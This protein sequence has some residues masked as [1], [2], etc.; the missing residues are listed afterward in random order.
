MGRP[1]SSPAG[2]GGHPFCPPFP[3]PPLS[4]FV[5]R[6]G[7]G[8]VGGEGGG[9]G[10]GGRQAE[11]EAEAERGRGRETETEEQR[12]EPKTGKPPAF[13]YTGRE[14]ET[15]SRVIMPAIVSAFSGERQEWRRVPSGLH[16]FPL[17]R[18]PRPSFRLGMSWRGAGWG[19]GLCPIQAHPVRPWKQLSDIPL[20]HAWNRSGEAMISAASWPTCAR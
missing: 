2:T 17:Q 20:T 16:C 11:A 8:G 13:G 10:G 3:T 19:R 9:G 4:A 12:A 15:D 14:R 1:S 6:V 5:G 7:G 18:G